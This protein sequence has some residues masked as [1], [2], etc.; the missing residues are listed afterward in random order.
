LHSLQAVGLG[1]KYRITAKEACMSDLVVI[2]FNDTMKA[3]E[4]LWRLRTLQSEDLVDL[5]DAVVVIRDQSGKIQLKQS[6]DLAGAQA[7]AGLIAGTF[8]GGLIG[9][10]FLNPTAGFLLGGMFGASA[11][12]LSGSLADY[13][14]DD[15]FIES[16][17]ETIP[18]N[19]SALFVLARKARQDKVL[20][21]LSDV[22]GKIL[23][24]SLSPDQEKR[25]REA[26]EGSAKPAGTTAT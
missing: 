15:D 4:V 22:G 9:M 14:I 19:S 6:V 3:D 5:E 10:L 23:K 1:Q 7:S 11:G 20:A 24:T 8:L 2:G 16:L 12:A 21:A 26:L 17:A 13:G 18:N 25:L